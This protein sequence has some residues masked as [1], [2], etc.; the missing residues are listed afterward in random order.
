MTIQED[1]FNS[2]PGGL[3]T[4]RDESRL[5]R[6]S[7]GGPVRGSCTYSLKTHRI[8]VYDLRPLLGVTFSVLTS[9]SSFSYR[10]K[11][12]FLLSVSCHLRSSF[13]HETRTERQ[14]FPNI[15]GLARCP[16]RGYFSP[17]LGPNGWNILTT[18]LASSRTHTFPESLTFKSM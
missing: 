3:G 6:P 9:F 18:L 10:V 13:T 5:P 8:G 1:R 7:V 11:L 17:V 16:T 14:R 15:Q 2:E 12:Y 4:C